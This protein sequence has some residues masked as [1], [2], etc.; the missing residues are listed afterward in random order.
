MRKVT[1]III[2]FADT[3]IFQVIKLFVR[4]HSIPECLRNVFFE[5]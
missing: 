4:Q 5:I 1:R 2:D 3:R